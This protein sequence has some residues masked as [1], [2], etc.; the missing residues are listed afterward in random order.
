M[1]KI[2][3]RP[4]SADDVI[5]GIKQFDE[6]LIKN[7][8]EQHRSKFIGWFKKN[9]QLD[10]AQLIELYQRAFTI[11]YTN[12]KDGKLTS[13]NS[14]IETY[15]YGIGKN[16]VKEEIRAKRK[17]IGFDEI[18]ISESVENELE[19]CENRAHAKEIVR[20]ILQKIGDPCKSI[21]TMYYFKNFSMES[22]AIRLGYKNE[23]VAK[24]KKCQCLQKIREQLVDEKKHI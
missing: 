2:T 16:L 14:T 10:D 11:F 24:K 9:H 15:L 8:Y 3:L 23:A 22:I 20:S 19:E 5:A 17:E 1:E 21:L 4:K 6:V 7:E 13:L 12:V 18:S